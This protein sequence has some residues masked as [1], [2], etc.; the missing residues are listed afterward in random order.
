MEERQR[1]RSLSILVVDDCP[2]NAESLAMLLRASGFQAE[3]VVGGEAAIEA[4]QS[5]RPEVLFVDLFMPKMEGF[6]LVRKLRELC[7]GRQPPGSPPFPA[8]PT[9]IPVKERETRE[10]ISSSSSR[11]ISTNCSSGWRPFKTK[12]PRLNTDDRSR[13]HPC[14]TVAAF[15]TSRQFRG[16]FGT[17]ATAERR[18]VG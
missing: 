7:P 12:W 5:R 13:V 6:V 3:A 8:G 16:I 15:L 10:W 17:A 11:S 14:V 9:K 18:P 4:F 2:D 1:G